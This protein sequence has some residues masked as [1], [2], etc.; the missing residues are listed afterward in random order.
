MS[1]SDEYTKKHANNNNGSSSEYGSRFLYK[2]EDSDGLFSAKKRRLPNYRARREPH[3]S[4]PIPI[5]IRKSQQLR[6]GDGAEVERFYLIRFKDMQQT[7]CKIMGKVFV[8]LVE[9]KKQTHH[10]YTRGDEKKPPWWPNTSGENHV[11]HVE[12]DHLLR[13]GESSHSVLWTLLKDIERIRLCVHILK[14]I[15]E[16]YHNQH[17]SIQKLGLNINKLEEVTMEA[18]SSWF[19]DK[20]CPKNALKRPFLKE[21]FKIAKAEERYKRDEIGKFTFVVWDPFFSD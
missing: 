15:T 6:I 8:K 3:D 2:I 19:N 14:M 21:I 7:S 17:P 20:E 10:P 13:P 12:P 1:N 16:P 9:P 4:T 5:P 11:R 18:L